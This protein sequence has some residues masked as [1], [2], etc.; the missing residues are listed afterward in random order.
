MKK[1]LILII[2]IFYC[3]QVN[4]ALT[5][6]DMNLS[7]AVESAKKEK[8]QKDLAQKK[9]MLKQLSKL[10]DAIEKVEKE[11]SKNN[12]DNIKIVSEINKLEKNQK[13]ISDRLSKELESFNQTTSSI[14]RIEHI[15][16]EMIVVQDTLNLQQR[17]QGVLAIFKHQLSNKVEESKKSLAKLAENLE[18]QKQK[19]LDLAKIQRRLRDKKI[20]LVEL[21]KQQK[22]ILN[23][24]AEIRFNMQN[25]ALLLAQDLNLNKFLSKVRK[26]NV[27]VKTSL[28]GLKLPIIGRIVKDYHSKDRITELPIQGIII[29]GGSRGK[30]KT[31]HD[32]RV[33]YSGQFREYGHLVILEH[34][35][36]AHSLYA[37]F[38]KALVDVGDYVNSGDL[39]GFLPVEE[40]PT[41]YYEVR[42][43]N[44]GQNPKKWLS[45][46]LNKV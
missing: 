8:I 33:I 1:S 32:G 2:S 15:P 26:K 22:K 36:G 41:L 38:G 34:Q 12:D 10:S 44:I 23:L 35:T 30:I 46:D 28:S 37:G 13:E 3:F 42:I 18:E 31:M 14:L 25:E 40:E 5:E 4:A 19:K 6:E 29:E 27:S 7:E 9:D 21:K 17:R 24:P 39:L 45:K 43:N 16:S 20:D 11:I